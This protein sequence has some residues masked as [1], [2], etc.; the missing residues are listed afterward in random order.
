[1]LIAEFYRG[2][3]N[4]N[5]KFLNKLI[6]EAELKNFI[7]KSALYYAINHKWHTNLC[8]AQFTVF[9]KKV[10]ELNNMTLD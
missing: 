1:M 5:S 2:Y 4:K 7:G 9:A 6:N 3:L 8:S 10:L